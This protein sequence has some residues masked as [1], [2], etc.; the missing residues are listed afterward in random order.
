MN[1]QVN[2]TFCDDIRHEVSGKISLIG[3]YAGH[4]LVPAFPL[5]LPQLCLVISVLTPVEHPFQKLILRVLKD[6]TV[7]IEGEIP[8]AELPKAESTPVVS[9]GDTGAPGRL[10]SVQSQI[11]ISPFT[12]EG[13]CIL[14]VRV[15][16]EAGE[17]KGQGLGV[18]LTPQP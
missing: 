17:L 10:L 4:M 13:P 16:T 1:R 11:V 7:L 12:A 14:R 18:Q 2:T 5:V 9:D 15:E 8:E 6:D 3:V